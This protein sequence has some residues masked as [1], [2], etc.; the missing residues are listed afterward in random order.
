MDYHVENTPSYEDTI[1]AHGEDVGEDLH[2]AQQNLLKS[3]L[4]RCIRKSENKCAIKN[5]D[6]LVKTMG[7][8]STPIDIAKTVEACIKK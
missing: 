5:L 3:D 1:A 6:Q 4:I 8:K 2:E 7:S